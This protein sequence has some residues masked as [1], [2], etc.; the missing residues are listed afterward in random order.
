MVMTVQLT[1][2]L[3]LVIEEMLA[4]GRF[5]D[6]GA[7]IEEAVLLLEEREHGRRLRASVA[8]GFAAIKRGEGV[9]LTPKLMDELAR[10]A[11]EYERDGMPLDP[12]VCP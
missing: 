7:V 4:T 12:D 2:K 3:E 8:E 9:E 10:E 6:A 11:D 1:P 5:A